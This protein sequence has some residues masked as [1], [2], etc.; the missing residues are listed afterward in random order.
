M[1]YLLFICLVTVYASLVSSGS[2]AKL[3]PLIV[4]MAIFSSI[5]ADYIAPDYLTYSDWYNQLT[6]DSGYL[7][8][9]SAF[10]EGL[11]F[12]I[13]ELFKKFG[14]SFEMFLFFNS[15]LSVGL[16][17]FVLNKVFSERKIFAVSVFVYVSTF[18]FLHEFIQIRVGV[19][20]GFICLGFMF[21]LRGHR[22]SQYLTVFCSSLYHTSAN[23]FYVFFYIVNN[24]YRIKIFTWFV[25][26]L[27]SAFML[28]NLNGITIFDL[29]K[30]GD[31]L[32][33][34]RLQFYTTEI[35]MNDG[36]NPF[37]LQ[38]VLLYTLCTVLLFNN[39]RLV[40]DSETYY[41]MVVKYSVFALLIGLFFL[42]TFTQYLTI[43]LRMFQ[44]FSLFIIFLF[45]LLFMCCRSRLLKIACITFLT[46][47]LYGTFFA[48]VPLILTYDI[49]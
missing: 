38:S 44:F 45:P 46:Y 49:F 37:S 14:L 11:F 40:Y 39:F 4:I 26:G 8:R 43:S 9:Q 1:I 36:A 20:S 24:K 42:Q 5:R 32:G 18:Y 33:V 25:W 41:L 28:L 3:I 31:M 10:D 27:I 16:K 21:A 48:D 12:L 7:E 17:I 23:V 22:I 13:L 15:L 19:A 35:D 34:T 29:D 30:I 2:F 47:S 6:E